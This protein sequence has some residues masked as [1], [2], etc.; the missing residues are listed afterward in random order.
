MPRQRWIRRGRIFDP[1]VHR[2]AMGSHAANPTVCRVGADGAILRVYYNFR[3]SQNR[4][5]IAHFDWSPLSGLCTTVSMKPDYLPGSVGLFDDSGVSLGCIVDMDDERRL[6]YLGWN[7]SRTV[8]WRNSIGLAV[9]RSTEPM[10][11]RYGAAP[12]CDRSNEDPYSLSY[13]WV[14]RVG[15]RWQMWYGSNLAWGEEP[16]S[17][18][19]VIKT[20]HSDD[21]IH[22][23][24]D[25]AVVVGL[26]GDEIGLSRPCVVSQ[27]GVHHMWYSARLP[28][29]YL[30][31][32]ARSNDGHVWQRQ[33]NCF[34]WRNAPEHWEQE[35]Q[36]YAC[37]FSHE[38]Q[39]HMLYNGN[40]YGR[41][42]IGWATLEGPLE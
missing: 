20:A 26:L 5:G 42:G 39:W 16:S 25:G 34:E 14:S 10:F 27:H 3:D 15:E 21:G 12:V 31:G 18:L 36:S 11:Q 2:E 23:R 35:S 13:P 38:G 24:R 40:G 9:G 8:P 6:Y 1:Q 17:M 29:S 4:A 19:H 37:V 33:D 30:I 41:T 7:L 28:S 22:W 32:Y